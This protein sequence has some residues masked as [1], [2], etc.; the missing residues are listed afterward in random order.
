M[1]YDATSEAIMAMTKYGVDE[2]EV[3]CGPTRLIIM[4]NG[5]AMVKTAGLTIPAK[6]QDEGNLVS[7]E[8]RAP[9]NVL[10]DLVRSGYSVT[11]GR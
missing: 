10:N 2:R 7:F 8:K 1:C 9:D 4:A 5:E 3:E 11:D 6:Y